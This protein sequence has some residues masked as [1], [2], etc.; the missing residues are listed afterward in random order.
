M[1][2]RLMF[3]LAICIGF[4]V[5]SCEPYVIEYAEIDTTIPIDFTEEIMPIF[6]S[7]CAV[8]HSTN[9]P[10]KLSSGNAYA[11]L[12]D[13]GYINTTSPESS[14]LYTKLL[15]GETHEGRIT[16]PDLEKILV[17]IQ[18]GAKETND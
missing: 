12:I 5:I 13:G 11:S 15:P 9:Q 2:K 6:K 18:Q 17:W 4:S 1:T 14:S 7:N 3:V 16:T 8:C 10:P